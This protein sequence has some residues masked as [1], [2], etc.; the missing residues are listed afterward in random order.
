MADADLITGYLAALRDSLAGRPDIEDLVSEVDDHLHCAAAGLQSRGPDPE[1]ALRDVLDRFGEATLVARSLSTT[2]SGGSV[3]PTRLTRTA[4]TFA[5]IASI[6]WLVAAPTSLI[7]AGS[8]EWETHYFILAL[9]VFIAAACTTVALVGLLRRAGGARAAV[10]VAA[11]GLAVLGTLVLGA[12]TW[13]WIL[14]VGLLA[15][16]AF[17]TV[18]RLRSARLGPTISGVLL[19]VVWPVGIAIGIALDALG[20]GPKDS[21]G[22]SYIAQLIGFA[23]GSL[24]FSAALPVWPVAAK[25]EGRRRIGDHGHRL[26]GDR[27]PAWGVICA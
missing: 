11:M 5:L 3:M 27:E 24:I 20:V 19:T 26:T 21:N 23:T 2:A 10:T 1:S 9:V 14:G 13:A 6:A 16:A 4:G 22:D 12:V 25:R 17:A 8:D 15:I 18:L 7:G